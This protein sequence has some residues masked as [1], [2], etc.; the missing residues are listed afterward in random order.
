MSFWDFERRV[1]GL[2]LNG[3]R[4]FS[5]LQFMCPQISFV[6]KNFFFISTGFWAKTFYLFSIKVQEEFQNS[7]LRV[8]GKLLRIIFN[9]L[10]KKKLYLI[11]FS[12]FLPELI[13]KPAKI[14]FWVSRRS[15]SGEKGCLKRHKEVYLLCDLKRIIF[16]PSANFFW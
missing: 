14:A 16:G 1:F 5:E 9:V 15:S 6:G 4:Q 13:G 7:I 2:S 11:S 10:E 8:Q 12:L 3:S